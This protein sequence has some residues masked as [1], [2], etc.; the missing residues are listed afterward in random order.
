M[1]SIKTV[2]EPDFLY[3]VLWTDNT[4]FKRSGVNSH[5]CWNILTLNAHHFIKDLASMYG[6]RIKDNQLNKP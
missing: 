5:G 2:D 4:A 1:A 6:A 3:R